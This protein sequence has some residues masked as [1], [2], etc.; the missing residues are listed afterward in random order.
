M[1]RAK[2]DSLIFPERRLNSVVTTV[3]TNSRKMDPVP[4]LDI[5]PEIRLV[6]R[7]RERKKCDYEECDGS[8]RVVGWNAEK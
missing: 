4:Q 5:P 6:K 7:I 2:T 3:I 8:R 1:T